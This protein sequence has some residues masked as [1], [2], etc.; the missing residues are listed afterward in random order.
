MCDFAQVT[1]GLHQL[2]RVL[3][4]M[5]PAFDLISPAAPIVPPRALLVPMPGEQHGFGLA[6]VVQFMRRAGWHVWSGAVPGQDDL[7]ALVRRESF[8]VI[9]F[10][11]ACANRLDD[12]TV[13]IRALRAASC[14]RAVA[15]MVGGPAFVGQPDLV[16]LV[17]ADATAHDGREAVQN[18][19]SLLAAAA[20]KAPKI[21]HS[22]APVVRSQQLAYAQCAWPGV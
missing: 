20:R 22:A 6:I 21:N 2:H 4:S 16:R 14:N 1:L 19:A 13:A 18:A 3:F 9:G 11:V 7:V 17:G 15:M 12:V 8:A 5:R 10:S